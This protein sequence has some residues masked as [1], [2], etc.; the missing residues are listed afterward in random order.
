VEIIVA[1]VIMALLF[2]TI[3]ISMGQLANARNNS[4]ARMDAFMRADSALRLIRA[5]LAS[6]LRR[7][8]LFQTWINIRDDSFNV[9]NVEFDRDWIVVF[10]N[11]LRA[12]RSIEYNGEG[13]EYESSWQVIEDEDGPVLWHR[14]DAMPDTYP[15]AGGVATP[16]IEGLLEINIEAFDGEQWMTE[17][18]SDYDGI[19][20]GFR[21]RVT[22][23]GARPG[24]PPL[25][26]PLATLR[27]IVSVDRA[28]LPYDV[29]D[30]RLAEQIAMDRVLPPEQ[31]EAIADAIAN[32]TALP[33]TP[34]SPDGGGDVIPG[35][36]SGSI[37]GGRVTGIPEGLP[38]IRPGGGS[39]GRM[40]NVGGN[41]GGNRGG[42]G[43][44]GIGGR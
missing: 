22:A 36:G 15:Q 20:R 8:D 21:I 14:R 34:P 2:A 26:A 41:V 28:P 43:G 3:A 40:G 32:G 24:E 29:L 1:G 12:I 44:S 7:H 27:T 33:L 13:L 16:V 37:G 19:P 39:D 42:G 10:N 4:R 6:L 35:L 11:H 9:D 25:S 30:W 31:I 18:D 17:W 5:D 38:D 23:T